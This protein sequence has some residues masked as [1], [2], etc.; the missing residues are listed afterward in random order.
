MARLRRRAC[1]SD[2]TGNIKWKQTSVISFPYRPRG[3]VPVEAEINLELLQVSSISFTAGDF[4]HCHRTRGTTGDERNSAS[5]VGRGGRGGLK[6]EILLC[7]QASDGTVPLGT[8]SVRGCVTDPVTSL[9]EFAQQEAEES[10]AKQT[11]SEGRSVLCVSAAENSQPGMMSS[12]E[13]C[14]LCKVVEEKKKHSEEI[15]GLEFC[16]SSFFKEASPKKQIKTLQSNFS[17]EDRQ[18]V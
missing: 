17:N 3:T 10:R 15:S 2:H 16:K 7:H 12:G 8:M 9:S 6:A 1:D 4:W 13:K 11:L 14:L 18:V 5:L